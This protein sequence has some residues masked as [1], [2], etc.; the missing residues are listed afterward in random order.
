MMSREGKEPQV[1][2][3][4]I[5]SSGRIVLP[6]ELRSQLGVREGDAVVILG[7]GAQLH[8]KSVEQAIRDAQELFVNAAPRERVLSDELLQE[9]RREAAR[10]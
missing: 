6:A 10:E 1:Y 7:D 2:R 9:R 3:S 4:K 8:V 5:D